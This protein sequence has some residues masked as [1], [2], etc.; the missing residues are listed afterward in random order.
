MSTRRNPFHRHAAVDHLIARDEH[1]RVVG[2]V[3]AT[4]HHAYVERYGPRAFFG[5][6]ESVPDVRVAQAL[7][8]AVEEWA[9][10]QG[11]RSVAGPYGYTTTQDVG[12]LVAG[13]DRPPTLM[14]PYNPPYYA[15]LLAACGYTESFRA[16]CYEWRDADRPD[17]QDLVV[18]RGHEIGARYGLTVRSVRLDD[19]TA[20]L[21]TVRHIYEAS[22]HDH[23]EHVPI[24]AGV[25]RYQV[26]ELRALVDPGLVRIV[27]H[28]GRP[29]AFVTVVPNLFE[30]LGRHGRITPGLVRRL[31][32]KRD[33]HIAGITSA[34]VVMMGAL[35]EYAGRGIGRVLGAEI[36]NAARRGG[37]TSVATTWIHDDNRWCRAIV[38]QMRLAPV[39]QYAVL[40][41]E[42]G[43][44]SRA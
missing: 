37:Y 7:L 23:P 15:D 39:K 1:D 36:V 16:S 44:P 3:A 27:E 20:E 41:R 34:I 10:R 17:R 25:F 19:Y 29:V 6:F 11:M 13:F 14:Q 5:F 21:D 33:H 32:W 2:R 18:D 24:A 8:G 38:N 22:F 30:I 28:D 40:E 26:G 4:V 43:E 42:W 12:L 35:P 9:A 31:A